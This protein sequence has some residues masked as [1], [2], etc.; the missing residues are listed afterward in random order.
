MLRQ[1]LEQGGV[2]GIDAVEIRLVA[3]NGSGTEQ[4][5]QD[6]Q[7]FLDEFLQQIEFVLIMGI[8][9]RTVDI[10]PLGDVLDDDVRKIPFGEQGEKRFRDA[11]TGAVDAAV[12]RRRKRLRH[13]HASHKSNSHDPSVG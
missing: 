5:G 4:V 12:V 7:A 6:G 1:V 10:A 13:D 3:L 8:K 9:R 11:L 2:E